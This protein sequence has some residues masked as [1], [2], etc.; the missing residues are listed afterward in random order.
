MNIQGKRHILHLIA[1]YLRVIIPVKRQL[2][3]G[4]APN[5]VPQKMKWLK[6]RQS[7]STFIGG[8]HPHFAAASG[9]FL[10][11]AASR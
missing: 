6:F 5:R 10:H 4:F 7:F 8:T 3:N 2:D 9:W 11:K 1:R